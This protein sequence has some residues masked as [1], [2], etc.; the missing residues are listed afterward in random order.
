M[1]PRASCSYMPRSHR[2]PGRRR[3][4]R[5]AAAHMDCDGQTPSC[6]ASVS[7]RAPSTAS[8]HRGWSREC[9]RG[10]GYT[11]PA[12]PP[13]N[14]TPHT[15]THCPPLGLPKFGPA[16]SPRL[17]AASPRFS[18]APDFRVP[19]RVRIPSPPFRFCSLLERVAY[20]PKRLLLLARIRRGGYYRLTPGDHH[21]ST[22]PPDPRSFSIVLSTTG[23]PHPAPACSHRA[24]RAGPPPVGFGK[25]DADAFFNGS[26]S[27]PGLYKSLHRLARSPSF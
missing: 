1:Q 25:N 24:M 16:A 3:F 13:P 5:P 26:R 22:S 19:C 2:L 7:P 20:L 12:I 11:G 15:G 23:S 18:V 4:R 10:L 21:D 8:H 17:G 6:A 27:R 14:P 9:V